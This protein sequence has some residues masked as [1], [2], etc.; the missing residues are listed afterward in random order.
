MAGR[1]KL[2]PK[3][4]DPRAYRKTML[5]VT[6]VMYCTGFSRPTIIKEINKGVLRAYRAE[7]CC[8][9]KYLINKDDVVKFMKLE[10]TA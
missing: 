6:E 1:K 7:E 9:S 4:R 8:G 10:E 5:S 3:Y 2:R